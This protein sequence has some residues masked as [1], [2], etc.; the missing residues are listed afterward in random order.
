MGNSYLPEIL[1]H[2]CIELRNW[3]C[4]SLSAPYWRFYWNDR[5]GG[6]LHWRGQDF[7]LEPEIFAVIPPQTDC[8]SSLCANPY[9]L[10]CNFIFPGGGVVLSPGVYTIPVPEVLLPVAQRCAQAAADHP[11]GLLCRDAVWGAQETQALALAF[12]LQ[13]LLCYCLTQLPVGLGRAQSGDSRVNL[14]IERIDQMLEQGEGAGI[15]N[16]CMADWAGVHRNTL[17]RLFRRYVGVCPQKYLTHKRLDYAC[18]LLHRQ[19]LRIE[20]IAVRLGYCDR[21]HFTREFTRVKG[22]APAAFRRNLP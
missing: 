7:P 14:V 4:P 3:N 19:T 6:A 17:A 5:P 8:R 16:E 9:H 20:E 12:T 2:S 18:I 13:T 10:N 15:N 11:Q 1:V 22:I 21:Y